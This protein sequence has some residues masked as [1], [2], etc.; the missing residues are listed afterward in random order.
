MFYTE[1]YLL[2]VA[3]FLSAFVSF[4]VDCREQRSFATERKTMIHATSRSSS[5]SRLAETQGDVVPEWRDQPSGMLTHVQDQSLSTLTRPHAEPDPAVELAAEDEPAFIIRKMQEQG[6]IIGGNA[7]YVGPHRSGP[8]EEI[9]REAELGPGRAGPLERAARD[10]LME[11]RRRAR[12]AVL[13]ERGNAAAR[14]GVP[15]AALTHYGESLALVPNDPAVLRNRAHAHLAR[16]DWAAAD[17]DCTHALQFEPGHPRAL[18]RRAVARLRRGRLGQARADASE[19]LAADPGN[20][21]APAH[22]PAPR[23]ARR[24]PRAALPL[25]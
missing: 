25:S 13:R 2:S 1:S 18:Y 4:S 15:D 10:E 22:T 21:Q 17:A 20:A 8:A 16:G 24:S 6:S 14:A 11:K 19:A 5:T 3:I 7:Y 23:R 9:M 12:A